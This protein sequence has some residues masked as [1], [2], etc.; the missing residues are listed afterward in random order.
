M[1]RQEVW[2][3]VC[4]AMMLA[5]IIA[6]LIGCANP[7]TGQTTDDATGQTTDDALSF[8]V[9]YEPNGADSGTA[10]DSQT[11][12][13]GVDLNL[14]GNTGNLT[15][16]RYAFGG[17][18][19]AADGTG[20]QYTADAV[21]ATNADL[22]LY[23]RWIPTY[24]VIFVTNDNRSGA[25]SLARAIADAEAGDEIRFDGGYSITVAP[26]SH[27][28]PGGLDGFNLDKDVVINGEGHHVELVG[29]PDHR[30][31]TVQGGSNVTLKHLDL[32]DGDQSSQDRNNGGAIMV[33]TGAHLTV[34]DV[35]FLS[36]QAYANG[37]A[38][39]LQSDSEA[40]IEDSRFDA[41]EAG[42]QGGA[43][44]VGTNSSLTVRNTLFIANAI[45]TNLSGQWVGG[46][47]IAFGNSGTGR[48]ESSSRFEGNESPKWG[49]ALNVTNGSIVEIVDTDFFGNRAGVV[50]TDAGNFGGGAINVGTN[51]TARIAGS[52]FELNKAIHAS[53][54]DR[55][56]GAIRNQGSLLSY[57]NTF[58]GNVASGAGG[59][60]YAGS[61]ADSLTVS[62]SSFA[63]NEVEPAGQ[64]GG[65][66]HAE[67][68]TNVI[69]YSSFAY[70]G[71][72]SGVGGIY[73]PDTGTTAEVHYSAFQFGQ[74]N[75]LTFDTI[76]S[77]VAPGTLSHPE[78]SDEAPDFTL[79]PDPGNDNSFGTADDSYG[80]LRP[81]MGSPLF[82]G[83]DSSFLLD[84][85][86]DLDGDGD[87]TED[88]PYDAAGGARVIGTV[89]IGA[90]EVAE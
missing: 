59:A 42:T 20:F 45:N 24:S 67:A 70:N 39:W 77:V 35:R 26:I 73:V 80:D 86:A 9:T 54:S 74:I 40:T 51:S 50:E 66:I 16:A 63:G 89:E 3:R 23:A 15:R 31:V 43:I 22:T 64:H 55:T 36:N 4:F 10:P 84:D 47:A 37:G 71:R 58:N 7:V 38:I 18:N 57:A 13:E 68:T 28:N 11:K 65:A 30:I 17:W 85:A 75:P 21:Y 88:E 46:G 69:Q 44:F 62:S 52:T 87:T 32:R 78:V 60:I 53:H 19:T 6:A 25:G 1:A 12:I 72:N 79:I 29:R 5:G 41:N 56:G 34:Q 2:R 49:G 8:T 48:I 33:S 27:S 83:A 61:N 81:A 14:S 82:G 90:Y 76:T